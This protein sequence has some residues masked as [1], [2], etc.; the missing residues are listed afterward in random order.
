MVFARNILPG[1]KIRIGNSWKQVSRVEKDCEFEPKFV[2]F[3]LDNGEHSPAFYA[4][5]MLLKS[6]EKKLPIQQEE[7]NA[8]PIDDLRTKEHPIQ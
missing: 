2:R 3:V 1:D 8:T 6:L 4:D 5:A 7:E